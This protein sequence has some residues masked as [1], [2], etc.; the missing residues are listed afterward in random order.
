MRVR[1]K[2]GRA[3]EGGD[4]DSLGV[5]GYVS[6]IFIKSSFDIGLCI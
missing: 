4:R 2:E 6:D 3:E 5:Q 1:V